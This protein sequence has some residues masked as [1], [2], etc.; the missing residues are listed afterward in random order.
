MIRLLRARFASASRG[1]ALVETALILSLILL[2]ALATFDL[3]RGIASHIALTEATQE[4]AIYA[5]YE[6][7]NPDAVP[8]VDAADVEYR[9]Q[10][11]SV[12]EA[13]TNAV[14][15]V[16][17]CDPSPGYV[18]VRST[19]DLPVISPPARLIF[20]PTFSLAVE[21]RATNLHGA[22]A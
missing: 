9:I 20:G 5:G 1:Q 13:V 3:G 12:G 18:V 22:C 2:L 15:T 16:P 6:L 11:S 19:Y 10:S 17:D 4:G 21:V 8:D 7:H 14:V